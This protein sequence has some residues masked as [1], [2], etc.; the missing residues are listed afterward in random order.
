MP[1]IEPKH[2]QPGV[3]VIRNIRIRD[4]ERMHTTEIPTLCQV[5]PQAGVELL[6]Y[7][8]RFASKLIGSVFCE[9]GN[10][11]L[12]GVPVPVAVLEQVS[13]PT[14]Q[15]TNCVTEEAG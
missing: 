4:G 14:G 15:A 5:A 13:C 9:L 11:R 1:V 6:A 3:S 8:I 2:Y 7:L 10:R 12:G